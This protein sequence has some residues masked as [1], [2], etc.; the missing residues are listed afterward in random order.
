[1][2]GGRVCD[3]PT[4]PA[5][6][7]RGRRVV[8]GAAQLPPGR[9]GRG[10]PAAARCCWHFT[11]AVSRTPPSPGNR[12]APRDPQAVTP[13]APAT[14]AGPGGGRGFLPEAPSPLVLASLLRA[15]SQTCPNPAGPS[16]PGPQPPLT[17]LSGQ[18]G[19]RWGVRPG[20]QQGAPLRQ[21]RRSH[22]CSQCRSQS[23]S[24]ILSQ[25]VVSGLF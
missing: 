9:A 7:P 21:D 5:T 6:S 10:L 15:S 18:A 13:P 3:C 20:S 4:T 23:R 16:A 14:S 22:R 1:M 2:G 19:G 17:C 12:V 25:P 11:D 8:D 24:F